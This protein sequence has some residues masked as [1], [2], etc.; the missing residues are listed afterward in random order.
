M[1]LLKEAHNPDIAHCPGTRSVFC[2]N[3]LRRALLELWLSIP[4]DTAET[5]L[6]MP[7][8]ANRHSCPCVITMSTNYAHGRTAPVQ[9]RYTG[10]S[11]GVAV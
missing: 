7:P 5:I 9:V 4:A 1:K 8:Q 11:R 2:K 10:R 6:L 3:C